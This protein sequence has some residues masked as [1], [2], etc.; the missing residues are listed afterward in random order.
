MDKT[1]VRPQVG[2]YVHPWRYAV[3]MLGTTIAAQMYNAY[4]SFF[5]ND[6]MG[7]PLT[8]ISLGMVI[9]STWDAVNGPLLGFLSDRTRTRFGRRRPW[10]LAG[11]PLF[12]LVFVLLFTPPQGMSTAVLAVYFTVLLMLTGTTNSMT[13][14]N[15]HALFPELFKDR[16]KRATAN[17]MRQSLQLVGMVIGVSLTPMLTQTLGYS[18][19]AMLLGAV[20]MGLVVYCALGVREDPAHAAAARP[21]LFDSF[22]TVLSNRNFWLVS[23][24]NFFY[25]ATFGL[26]MAATPFFVKYTLGL[27]GLYATILSGAIFALAI[28]A[29]AVWAR[30]IR[31]YGALR[32][33]RW[34]LAALGLAFVPLLFANSLALAL[35]G[36][37][38]VGF[39][40]AGV[41]ANI[42]LITACIIDADRAATGIARE[43]VFNSTFNF[44][45]RFSSLMRSLVFFLVSVWFGFADGANPGHSPATAA[46]FMMAV[47]PIIF[48][49]ISVAISRFVRIEEAI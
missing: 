38:F 35:V 37:A 11:A 32:V 48:M 6:Q 41:T 3:G 34:A 21:K 44:L 26:M 7:L 4:A 25:Q 13:G 31:T 17:A 1:A 39:G 24:T 36:G 49:A 27:D 29:M 10:M 14:M 5:Y 47:F 43:G 12:L 46:R 19:T 20:S 9:C 16:E 23:S 33:W 42:D 18:H 45:V 28:P 15:Y 30:L 22:R 40:L 8:M 2:G